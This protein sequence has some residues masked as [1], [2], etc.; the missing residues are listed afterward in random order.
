MAALELRAYQL[1]CVDALRQSYATRHRAPGFVLA[2]GAGK[3]IIFVFIIWGANRKQLRTLLV[4][5]RR[6]LLKQASAKLLLAGVSHGII[7]AGFEPDQDQ[8]VQVASIQTAVRRLDKIGQFDL[9]VFDEA[10]HC[11]AETWK[12]LIE[13]QPKAK[14]LGVTAT[15]V[16]ADGKGLGIEDGGC[17]DDLVVGPSIEELVNDGYLSPTRSFVPAQRLD[18]HGVRTQAGDYVASDVARVVDTADITGDAVEQYAK[19]ADHQPAIA[20]CA[21]VE[22][23]QHVAE[24]FLNAGY[25]ARCVHGGT[26]VDERDA[27]IEGL[28]NGETEIL[29]A[30]DL[31]SEGLDVPAVGAVILLRPTKSFGLHMQQI[32]RG[33]RVAPNTN[34]LIVN[35]HVG[36]I[37]THGLPTDPR[38]WTLRGVEKKI[39]GVPPHWRCPECGCLNQMA[40]LFCIQCGA[41]RPGEDHDLTV[42]A[43]ELAELTADRLAAMRT[44][45]FWEMASQKR[46]E[47]ELREF[48]RAHKYHWKWVG[49]RL[50][51]QEARS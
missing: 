51:D 30:C 23:A 32:G 45:S 28:G 38:V 25:L 9:I 44:M 18:L 17:F 3:T 13:T 11:Q 22:H 15:P 16:R 46:S 50:R 42:A 20:F 41:P 36:N 48:A 2:T 12:K 4:V 5:H 29:T 37:I 35:D 7:A 10:H 31:I 47:A 8:L 27:A 24:A 43:G 14:L 21:T 34:W 19:R 26:P 49:H 1:A 39:G 33:M 40:S 6:E